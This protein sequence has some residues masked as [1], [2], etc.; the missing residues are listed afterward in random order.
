MVK[1]EERSLTLF[2]E[3][4]PIRKSTDD[5]IADSS[6]SCLMGVKDSLV[7]MLDM[8]REICEWDWLDRNHVTGRGILRVSLTDSAPVGLSAVSFEVFQAPSP[9]TQQVTCSLKEV[10]LGRGMQ[11][12]Y[13]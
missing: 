11:P 12:N 3:P 5:D 13:D 10:S 4:S 2:I 8:D 7:S 9:L 1:C 6:S